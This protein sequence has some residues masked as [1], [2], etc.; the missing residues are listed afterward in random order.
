MEGIYIF[1]LL[2]SFIHTIMYAYYGA[3]AAGFRFSAKPLITLTQII[4]FIAGFVLGKRY[5]SLEQFRASPETMLAYIFMN[6]YVFCVLLLFIHFFIV[7][8]FSKPLATRQPDEPVGVRASARAVSALAACDSHP[9]LT[10]GP[11]RTFPC[12]CRASGTVGRSTARPRATESSVSK[13]TE[14][15]LHNSA[16]RRA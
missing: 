15:A 6:G 7:D 10:P 8:N 16:W 14:Q 5:L 11:Y 12:A 13:R 3:T 4:Q 2:N 1:C 9:C